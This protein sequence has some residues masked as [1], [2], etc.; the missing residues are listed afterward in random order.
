MIKTMS[1]RISRFLVG[2]GADVDEEVLSYGAECFLNELLS[3][4]LLILIGLLT[5]HVWELL[6]WSVSF[7]LL[8][9]NLGGLHASSHG[10][11]VG[12]G[13]L[14]GASSI[15]ISP[16]LLRYAEVSALLTILALVI[17]IVI[18]PVR[19][20]NKQHVQTKRKE[21]KRKVAVIGALE[22]LSVGLVYAVHPIASSYIASGL[23]MATLLA[24]A[25]VI[26]NPR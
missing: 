18:A 15:L 14:I 11:C 24:L 23:I 21:L 13:T 6:L 17:A 25:G 4:A 12:L 1:N 19:H 16:W 9:V 20:K 26:W 5:H 2:R 8:R 10:W 3:N 7:C 22:V